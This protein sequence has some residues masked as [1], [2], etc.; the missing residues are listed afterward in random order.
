MQFDFTVLF[1]R[2]S[3][4]MLLA[5]FFSFL[6]LI[7]SGSPLERRQEDTRPYYVHNR[8]PRAINLFIGGALDQVIPAGGDVTKV[9][10]IGANFWYTDVNG[11]RFNGVGTTRA[12]FWG[13]LYWLIKD[14]GAINTG[15]T[16]APRLSQG[17]CTEITCNDANCPEAFI[18][19]PNEFPPPTN[20]TTG[21]PHSYFC[22]YPNLT[23]DITFCP[24]GQLP[25]NPG[26]AIHPNGNFLKCM[27][28]RGAQ[29]ASGT[30]VQVY[31][32]ND[33]PAQRWFITRGSTK[34]QLAGTNFCLD[35]GESPANGV[36]LKIWQCYDNLP[37]QQWHY[38]DDNR[39]A[40]EGQGQCTD[41]TNG[42]FTNGNQLQTWQCT[43]FNTNQIWNV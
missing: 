34:I 37:A 28:V 32:C 39:I 5:I 9:A 35:A 29:F 27:D 38:T 7:T 15:L 2:A 14:A 6:P 12:A 24:D 41:L 23:F 18:G 13:G 8:C 43:D 42:L 26:I 16:V 31:D 11:G 3:P 40:L 17:F 19:V 22:P 1:H 10:N 33:T 4:K 25:P 21:G 20:S 36:G 30:A